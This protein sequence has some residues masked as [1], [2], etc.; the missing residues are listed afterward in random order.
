MGLASAVHHREIS[1]VRRIDAGAM[2]MPFGDRAV[3]GLV[4]DHEEPVV[5]ASTRDL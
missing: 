5:T 4:Q 1:T 2:A 3:G